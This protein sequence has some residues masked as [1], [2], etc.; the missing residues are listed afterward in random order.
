MR[1]LALRRVLTIT[2]ASIVMLLLGASAAWAPKYLTVPVVDGPCSTAR[3][4]GSLLGQLAP[5]HFF[6]SDGQL[7]VLGNMDGTCD[8]PRNDVVLEN[9]PTLTLATVLNS[10]CRILVLGLGPG[11]ATRSIV[12]DLEGD[13]MIFEQPEDDPLLCKIAAAQDS[14]RQ[15]VRLMNAMLA[16]N[17]EEEPAP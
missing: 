11:A 15:L 2:S 16:A 10:D 3:Q 14:P 8:L 13:P 12:Y 6:Q 17:A 5:R 1:T 7:V 4:S 9:A